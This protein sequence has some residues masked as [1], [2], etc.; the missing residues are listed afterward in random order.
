MSASL[1]TIASAFSPSPAG[2]GAAL[3]S[4][5]SDIVL[6]VA[7]LAGA[8]AALSALTFWSRHIVHRISRRGTSSAR[9]ILKDLRDGR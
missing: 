7:L 8:L 5:T 6:G 2:G 3:A 9:E 1:M 4:G